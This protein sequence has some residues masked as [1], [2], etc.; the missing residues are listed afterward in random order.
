MT[1][2]SSRDPAED[3]ADQIA[4]ADEVMARHEAIARPDHEAQNDRDFWKALFEMPYWLFIPA[5]PDDDP[6]PHAQV[7][8]DR[9]GI[10]AFLYPQQMLEAALAG[11]I[12]AEQA[13]RQLAMTPST[14]AANSAEYFRQGILDLRFQSPAGEFLLP[15][16][17]MD[18]VAAEAMS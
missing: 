13:A 14:V 4:R 8:D 2:E 10:I 16:A 7:I 12:P 17:Q 1:E 11:G 9:P 6:V 18:A 15:L 5:G 3:L